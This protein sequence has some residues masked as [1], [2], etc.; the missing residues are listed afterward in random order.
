[1]SLAPPQWRHVI[2]PHVYAWS[3]ARK[4]PRKDKKYCLFQSWLRKPLWKV[5]SLKQQFT[6][7][8]FI[9]FIC[10]LLSKQNAVSRAWWQFHSGSSDCPMHL[11]SHIITCS[12][13]L[14]I[15]LPMVLL[16]KLASSGLSGGSWSRKSYRRFSR[17]SSSPSLSLI[18]GTSQVRSSQAVFGY[19]KGHSSSTGG[20]IRLLQILGSRHVMAGER[21]QW[22]RVCIAL[23]E[24]LS[25]T[26]SAHIWWWSHL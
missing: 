21:G 22:L 19:L 9:L 26:P 13:F 7:Q 18:C 4:A 23:S 8:L 2:G 15:R 20:E 25:S 14:A 10:G 12:V 16:K 3:G 5:T 17:L 24:N 11:A 1:M 6:Y